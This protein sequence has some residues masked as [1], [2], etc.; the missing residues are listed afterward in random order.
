M[1]T[2]KPE[3]P[4]FTPG[5]Y[6]HFHFSNK[7]KQFLTP[8]GIRSKLEIFNEYKK[9]PDQLTRITNGKDKQC[10]PVDKPG[11]MDGVLI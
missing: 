8:D 7:G 1:L 4:T 10:I 2:D 9:N 6:A 11:W 3:Q 5:S